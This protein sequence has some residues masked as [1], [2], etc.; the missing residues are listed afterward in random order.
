MQLFLEEPLDWILGEDWGSSTSRV[1]VLEAIP[2]MLQLT[3][4]GI[5][6]YWLLNERD[7]DLDINRRRVRNFILVLY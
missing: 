1:F 6:L 3:F 2:A 4:I 7:A 5:S